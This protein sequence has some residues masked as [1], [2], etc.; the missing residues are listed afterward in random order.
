MNEP[1][2]LVSFNR[3]SINLEGIGN[4]LLYEGA[5]TDVGDEFAVAAERDPN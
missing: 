3:K 5:P 4:G 2:N 1:T